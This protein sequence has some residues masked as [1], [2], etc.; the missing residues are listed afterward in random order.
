MIH[1]RIIAGL[2]HSELEY[3]SIAGANFE[4][5]QTVKSIRDI[6]ASI[7]RTEY[8][9]Y[10]VKAGSAIR[11]GIDKEDPHRLVYL[12]LDRMVRI[13]SITPLKT[14]KSG[15]SSI[16]RLLSPDTIPLSSGSP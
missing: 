3:R 4:G 9:S 15:R 13:F 12:Y 11:T 14:T 8:G 2:T 16:I 7:D 6:A 5:L 10:N 1:K